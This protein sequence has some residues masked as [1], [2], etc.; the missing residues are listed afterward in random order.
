MSNTD[1]R[2]NGSKD[3]FLEDYTRYI[4]EQCGIPVDSLFAIMENA[5]EVYKQ[6]CEEESKP[7]DE[8]IG[9]WCDAVR[10]VF[11]E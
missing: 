9:F 4:A 2:K 1:D 6:K 11:H 5:G 10:E 7:R 3:D 8:A